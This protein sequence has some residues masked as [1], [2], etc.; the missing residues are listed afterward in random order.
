MS[1]RCP[2]RASCCYF[3]RQ[4][5]PAPGRDRG[6]NRRGDSSG[7]GT[8]ER[9]VATRVRKAISA[10][11]I[12]TRA[13]PSLEVRFGDNARRQLIPS[14]M[15]TYLSPLPETRAAPPARVF[16]FPLVRWSASRSKRPLQVRLTDASAGATLTICQARHANGVSYCL[17]TSSDSTA[18]HVSRPASPLPSCMLVAQFVSG[19]PEGPVMRFRWI[20]AVALWTILSGPIFAP[21]YP[22]A[23]AR[24]RAASSGTQTSPG[25]PAAT[26]LPPR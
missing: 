2:W 7:A 10:L 19:P 8:P 11:A 9:A 25:N 6:W 17:N 12:R 24:P 26:G 15:L 1:Q 18:H 16:S 23:P 4:R 13:A 21:S 22:T 3:Q 5:R 14:A 20:A